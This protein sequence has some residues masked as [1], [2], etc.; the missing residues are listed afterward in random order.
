MRRRVLP[1][2]GFAAVAVPFVYQIDGAPAARDGLTPA[3]PD[4]G[5]HSG[6]KGRCAPENGEHIRR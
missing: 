3:E 6:Y 2:L 1:L 4:G 5:E